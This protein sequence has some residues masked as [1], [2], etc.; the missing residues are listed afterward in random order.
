MTELILLEPLFARK[1]EIG[2]LFLIMQVLG[3]PREDNWPGVS[4]LPFFKSS[5]PKFDSLGLLKYKGQ[6]RERDPQMI[7]LLTKMLQ[8]NPE[9]R[10]SCTEALSHP[11]FKGMHEE[12]Q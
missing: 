4:Q 8:L 3:S 9:D 2:Q 12:F 11:F 5:F 10:L 1:C 6:L 7:D